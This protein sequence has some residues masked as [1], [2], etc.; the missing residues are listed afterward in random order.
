MAC[1]LPLFHVFAMTVC[2]NYLIKMGG[3][4]LILPRFD[5]AQAGQFL[6]DEKCTFFP[7]VPTMFLALTMIPDDMVAGLDKTLKTVV[8]GGAPLP[9]EIKSA[10][11]GKMGI[12][13]LEGYG[14]SET[15]PVACLLPEGMASVIGS[16]GFPVSQ[17]ELSL[18]DLEDPEKP[19]PQGERGEVCL[20]GPQVMS[21]YWNRPELHDSTFTKDG[22]FRTGDVAYH[23]DDGYTYIVDRIKDL[24]LCSGFNVYPRHIEEAL[25]EHSDITEVIVIGIPHPEKGEVPK[26]YVVAKDK[27]NPPAVDDLMAY[28]KGKIKSIEMPADIEFRSE[29]PKTAVGKLSKKDLREEL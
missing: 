29:L 10:F 7:G 24:I 13:M 8:S 15:S 5:P 16:I 20:R 27:D 22:F 28:L 25:F 23:G 1:V 19:V 17:T 9:A 26:A 6:R 12:E 18:R 3:C 4:A 11:E 2:M 21:G 14:L